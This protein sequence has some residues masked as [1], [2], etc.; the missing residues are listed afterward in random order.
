MLTLLFCKGDKELAHCDVPARPEYA[1]EVTEF[2]KKQFADNGI[3]KR[4][5]AREAVVVDEVFA[6]CC[7]K[8]AL[9]SRIMVECGVA[10]DALMV[11]IRVTAVLGGVDPMESENIETKKM[12]SA[13]SVK[14][15][16]ISP[17]CRRRT[18]YDHDCVLLKL[19][20]TGVPPIC[21]APVFFAVC[22]IYKDFPCVV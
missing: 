8:A 9:D 11:N 21:G 6:L 17:L 20:E 7:R 14:M 18:G 1:G 19:N 2:L 3:D 22:A 10:P 13:L 15:P 12:P 16:N 4:H 5:Y